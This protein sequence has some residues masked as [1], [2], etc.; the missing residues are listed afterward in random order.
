M[1]CAMTTLA[2]LYAPTNYA[3]CHNQSP[4]HQAQ[5]AIQDFTAHM[6]R[7]SE[8]KERCMSI[9]AHIDRSFRITICANHH[10]ESWLS[11]RTYVDEFA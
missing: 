7:I 6:D 9:S 8:R 5:I 3:A 11:N 4:V 10:S 1:S 2:A